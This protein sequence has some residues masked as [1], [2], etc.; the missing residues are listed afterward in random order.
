MMRRGR[1][2]LPETKQ[3]PLQRVRRGI[4]PSAPRW[5]Q[6]EGNLIYPLANEI[7]VVKVRFR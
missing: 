1:R 5:D 4:A 2:A 7:G 6:K 3:S